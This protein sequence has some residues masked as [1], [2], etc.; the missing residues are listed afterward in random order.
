[1]HAVQEEGR[2]GNHEYLI[3]RDMFIPIWVVR[4]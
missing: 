2:L 4:K 1:M 3:E